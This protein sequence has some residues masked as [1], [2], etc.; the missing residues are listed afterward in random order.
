MISKKIFLIIY[1]IIAKHLPSTSQ[2]FGKTSNY[3][4]VLICKFI[5]KKI[6]NTSIIKRGVYF[7]TGENIKIGK[8]SQIGENCRVPNN[9][10]IGNYVMMGIECI[11]FGVKHKISKNNIPFIH[12]GY[13]QVGPIIIGNNVWIGARVIILPGIKIGN[14]SIIAAGSV[15]TKNIKPNSLYAGVPAKKIKTI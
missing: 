11:L 13:D 6:Y 5:F 12:Q 8:N 2:P 3:L 14:N 7:G 10:V 9:I 4:R 15:V 1:Y